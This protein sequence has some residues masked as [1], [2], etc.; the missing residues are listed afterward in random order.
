[1]NKVTFK[2]NGAINPALQDI[3]FS[4]QW[5]VQLYRDAGDEVGVKR[6]LAL[7]EIEKA[8][9]AERKRLA[10]ETKTEKAP[11]P[12]YADFSPTAPWR[13]K[14]TRSRKCLIA[15]GKSKDPSNDWAPALV[16]FVCPTTSFRENGF[17][18]GGDSTP[19]RAFKELRKLK[20]GEVGDLQEG[21]I[22]FCG[23]AIPELPTLKRKLA[24][25]P[26]FSFDKAFEEACAKDDSDFVIV[27]VDSIV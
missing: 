21:V 17:E 4:V 9:I 16:L 22:E 10:A 13:S 18:A 24:S 7:W 26:Y 19:Q 1:M 8:E 23:S 5:H 27:P 25:V 12:A 20:L 15:I 14:T 6:I 11:L 3:P 2:L